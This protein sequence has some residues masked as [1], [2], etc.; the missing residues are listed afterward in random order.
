MEA[1]L[2]ALVVLL[3]FFVEATLGFG[4][5]VVAVVLGC[6]L[7][8]IELLLAAFVP[9]NL[10]L[11]TYIVVRY[12]RDLDR[13]LLL[14]RI[15]PLM[16]AGMPAGMLLFAYGDERL[17]KT[18]FGLF[19]VALSTAEL[20]RSGLGRGSPP[21][22]ELPGVAKVALLLAGGVVHGAFAT[23]G[24]MAVYVAGRAGLDK[25]AFRATLSA[26]WLVLNAVLLGSYAFSG[27]LTAE[28]AR[29]TVL[30]FVPLVG[31]LALGEW[32]HRRID[33]ALF[34]RLVYAGLLLAGGVLA[35]QAA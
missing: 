34:G 11:S 16:A 31:G 7:L 13:P 5:T 32:L 10:M 35:Y 14:K 25:G 2:F 29:L 1:P 30:L 8:P 18:L 23:G 22:R 21:A 28:S 27:T 33:A 17:L 15:L 6:F 20:L 3:A 24:P 4:A 19:V 9:L 26:L 12:R